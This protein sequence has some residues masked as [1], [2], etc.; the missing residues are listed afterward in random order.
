LRALAADSRRI[1]APERV[2]ARLRA[3]WRGQMGPAQHRR[4]ARWW[5]P[6]AQ[7]I[8][9]AAAVAALAALLIYGRPPRPAEHRARPAGVELA[10][11]PFAEL[12]TEA[13][14]E[15]DFIPLPNVEAL[16]PND[17]VNLVRIEVPRS[18]LM[19][20]GFAVSAER[21]LEPVEAD[22]VLGPDGQA[23]AVRFLDE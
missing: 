11:A 4:S 22:V 6:L 18:A 17:E 12:T 21:A 7:G 5:N 13:F 10:N 15:E 14:A 20:L 23:R 19:A 1:E 3:A 8:A 9:S 2:E 16:G